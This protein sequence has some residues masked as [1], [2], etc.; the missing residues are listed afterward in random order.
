MRGKEYSIEEKLSYVTDFKASGQTI[1]NFCR[2]RNIPETTLRD[3][4]KLDKYET[5]GAI[6]LNEP[7]S[8]IQ[9]PIIK[10]PMI[11]VG[12]NIRIE[13]KEGFDKLFLKKIV[14]VLI[15]DI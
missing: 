3:W 10:Q 13:L 2:D 9:K 8:E 1:A 7:S 15:N 4:I 6:S 14:E 5:F 11:F 12:P